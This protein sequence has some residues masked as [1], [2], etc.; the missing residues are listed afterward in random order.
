[1]ITKR[2]FFIKLLG[3]LGMSFIPYGRIK[4]KTSLKTMTVLKVPM[5]LKRFSGVEDCL[6]G[7]SNFNYW[8]HFRAVKSKFIKQGRL[9]QTRKIYGKDMVIFT[10]YKTKEDNLSFISEIGG[11]RVLSKELSLL[12][13]H[14]RNKIIG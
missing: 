14:F 7:S 12:N 5:D 2:D 8:K 3:V 9:F 6:T 1:M 4:E 13:I 11:L 10:S